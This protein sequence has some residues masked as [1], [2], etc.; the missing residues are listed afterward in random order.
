MGSCVARPSKLVGV[1]KGDY[2]KSK[3]GR[4]HFT[5]KWL[6]KSK[7]THS[8]TSKVLKDPLEEN[9]LEKYEIGEELG[10]GEFGITYQCVHLE[11]K[12][13]YACKKISKAKLKTDIDVEDV[14]REVEIMMHLP[15][16][17]NLVSFREAFEDNDAVYLVME[18]CRGGELFDRIVAK[19]HYTERA[20]AKVIK[21]ILEIVK[22]CHRHGVVHRDLKPENFLLA[23]E[24]E[25][26]P[27]KVIDFGLS[28]FYEP[29]ERFSD[30]VGSPYYMAPEVLRRNYG[31]EIDI[32]STG[33]IL[34]ILLCGVP[35]F[36]ADT[37]EGIAHAI[38]RGEIDF[39]RDPWPKISEEAKDLVTCMLDPNP[40]TRMTVQEVLEH[41]WIQNLQQAPNFNLG[42]NVGTR[43]KQ[44]SLMSKFKKKILR[45]V[46]NN[47]P[48]E[49]ID[50]II[51]MF[52]TMDTDDNGYLS[53][54]ELRDGLHKIGHSVSDH[55]V[56]M[57]MEAA[58]IDGNGTL[59]CEEFV[60][61]VV[62][63]KRIG[64]DE[65]LTQAFHHFDTNQ[66]G[67]I[68]FEELREALLQDDPGPNNEQLIKDIMQ[69]VDRDKDGRIS[70][71]EFKAMMLSGMEWKMAS[72]QYSRALINAVS[73]KILRQ[74][75]Q[76]K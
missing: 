14:T 21:T 35:P 17:P 54:E 72:R 6:R 12:E 3:S 58:D 36:W 15:K 1:R 30:I 11:T 61:M 66:S 70:F 19:G 45:V 51:E 9:I 53:F 65:H 10:R 41:T 50:L 20:A 76:L 62:H 75:G 46:A 68:E 37:E 60:I 13:I 4:S 47:L 56:K 2:P 8:A 38:I 71:Q 34:Y 26:A 33:V 59:S 18:L 57:L 24:S 43:I 49:Q 64:N 55:D 73:I 40:Y 39:E 63:L 27:I 52:N 28:I 31:K 23:D 32:W 74:S 67:Y 69:D 7:S 44:F 22:V 5:S 42:E 25:A 48:N 16:H 29:G